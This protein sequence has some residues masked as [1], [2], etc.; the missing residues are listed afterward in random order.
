L[1]ERPF[2][3]FFSCATGFGTISLESHSLRV[4]VI[5]GELAVEKLLLTQGGRTRTVEWK[6]MARPD[7]PAARRL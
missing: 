6:A 3:T 7:S 5:E 2:K 1:K 4:E